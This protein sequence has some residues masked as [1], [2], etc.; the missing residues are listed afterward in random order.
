MI[1]LRRWRRARFSAVLGFAMF[2]QSQAIGGAEPGAEARAILAANCFKC[3]GPTKQ[4]GGLRFDTRQ[5]LL[6]KGD[7][8]SAAVAP[9]KPAA[10]EMMRRVESKDDTVR[11]PPGEARLNA[12][13]IA[14]LRKWIEAGAAGTGATPRKTT[15]LIVTDEDR[16]HWAFRP[17]A[18]IE[19]PAIE[20]SAKAHGA[21]DRFILAGLASKHLA[22]ALP[23]D[24]RLLIRRVTFD[25]VGLPP[26]PD[27][28]EA[29]VEAGNGE[30]AYVALVDRLLASPHYGERWGRHWLDVARYAD[31][32]GYESDYDRPTA[33]HY[34]D[35]VIEALNAD[36]PFDEFVRWQLAGD[37]IGPDDPRAIAATGF[38]AAGPAELLPDKLLEE[39]R[40]R[41]RYIELDDMVSTT[42][43]AFLGL[44]L[45]CARCHDH[46]F[47]PIPAR[48]YY[49]LLA[50]LQ[51]GNRAESPL[52]APAEIN[53]INEA[54]A[55]WN[56]QFK[57]A[58]AAFK[59][60][61]SEQ[62]AKVGPRLRAGKIAKLP[63]SDAEKT[64]L[65]EKPDS[66]EAKALA[67]KH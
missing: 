28:V 63:A 58:E 67:K 36:K 53:R 49:R 14:S 43:A 9:G 62:R 42:G 8:G 7:S 24:P 40:I 64:L 1:S 32:G 3:H 15:E 50:A 22:P 48:D 38:L 4:K 17:L 20:N 34:R 26:A 10:S 44:T 57:A 11:M 25:V 19:P 51:S 30:K 27:E 31:S 54:R 23:A 55:E 29:F 47:D 2:L 16:R 52:A 56:K 12:E 37:E 41:Q 65:R 66:P 6:G 13:E 33:Y 5:G 39:E 18:K 46:K 59:K 45:G 35:F 61:V 21:I 60:W